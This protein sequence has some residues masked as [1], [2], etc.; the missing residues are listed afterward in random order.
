VIA[1]KFAVIC[2]YVAKVFLKCFSL[3]FSMNSS[4]GSHLRPQMGVFLKFELSNGP[5]AGY[6]ICP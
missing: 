3:L 2:C 6:I 5:Q 1:L 4:R